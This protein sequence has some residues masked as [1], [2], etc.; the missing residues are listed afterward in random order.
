[1]RYPVFRTRHVGSATPGAVVESHQLQFSKNPGPSG[2]AGL[3]GATQILRAGNFAWTC[4]YASPVMGSGAD[5]PCQGEMARRARGGRVGDYE[6]EV[7]IWSRPRCVL[8]NPSL[9][10]AKPSEAGSP[11]R[12]GARERTQFSPPGGNGV[13]WTQG[14]L[15]RRDK[16][17][18]P[19]PLRRRAAMGKVTRRRGGEILSAFPERNGQRRRAARCAAP[20]VEKKEFLQFN[21]SC[22]IMH[23]TAGCGHQ[24][25]GSSQTG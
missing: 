4:R 6:H 16:R 7:L 18:W 13:E 9:L 20:P 17:R 1:M 2:P 23:L 21:P 3:E 25:K 11:G 8:P 19:G 12:G 14:E 5:S 22:A 10:P 24:Q 15:A